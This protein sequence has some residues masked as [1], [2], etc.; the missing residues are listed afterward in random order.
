[1]AFGILD[2]GATMNFL[3][4]TTPGTDSKKLKHGTI[5]ILPD[6]STTLTTNS[7]NLLLPELPLT[8]CKAEIGPF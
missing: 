3:T 5:V 8:V 6:G 4:P 1:M 2:S 7:K